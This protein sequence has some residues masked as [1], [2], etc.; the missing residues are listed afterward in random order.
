MTFRS[1][2]ASCA[3]HDLNPQVYLEQMLRLAPHWPVNRML[4]LSPKYWKRTLQRL[5]DRQRECLARPWELDSRTV[6]LKAAATAASH[7]A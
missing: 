4:E 6:D 5:D 1:L 2:I 3:L 7:A